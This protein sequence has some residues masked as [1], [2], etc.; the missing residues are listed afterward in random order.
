MI[1][2]YLKICFR[3]LAKHTAYCTINILGLSIGIACCLILGLYLSIELNYDKHN[4]LHERIYRVV[5]ELEY[6]GNV[7]YV[8]NTSS[9]LGPF[10]ARDFA[11]V[12]DYVRFR[13][14]RRS[15][16]SIFRSEDDSFYWE[17][18]YFADDNLFQLFTHDIIYGDPTTALVDP[19]SIAVSESFATM[20]FGG[21]NPLG[22]IISNDDSDY[23]I[24]LVFADLPQ[25]SHLN[26]EA[27]ISYNG[28]P[29]PAT[30][31]EEELWNL[32]LYTYVLLP[33]DFEVE[34][35]EEI[36]ELFF[37]RHMADRARSLGINAKRRF[38]VEPLANIHLQSTTTSDLPRGNK[39][40]VYGSAVIAAFVLIVA[41]INYMNLAT[42]LS[43]SKAYEVGMRKILGAKKLHLA[44]QVIGESLFLTLLSLPLAFLLIRITLDYTPVAN[45]L[46]VQLSMGMFFAPKVIALI[47]AATISLGFLSGFY[48]AFYL[49]AI[50]PASVFKAGTTGK[51]G[52]NI[53]K[54]LIFTQFTASVCILAST[55]MML[56]QMSY[57]N[58][59]PLGF[60]KDNKMLIRVQGADQVQNLE[61][62]MNELDQV[63]GIIGVARSANMFG[64]RIGTQALMV[65]NNDG[66]PTSRNVSRMNI[67]PGFIDVIGLELIEGRSFEEVNVDNLA[68]TAI[69]NETLANAMGWD[70]SQGKN[71]NYTVEGYEPLQVIGVLK[72]FHYRGL[73]QEI[74]PVVITVNEPDF[75]QFSSLRRRLYSEWLV[76][77]VTEE[78]VPDIIEFLQN[79]WSSFDSEHPFEF[80]FLNDSLNEIYGSE[81]REMK[82]IGVFSGICIFV[83]CMGLFGLSAF[84]TALRKKEIGVRKVL[85]ATASS[86]IFMLFKNVL[87]LILSASL[88]ASILSYWMVNIW[89]EGFYYRID[90]FSANLTVYIFSAF[91]VLTVAFVTMAL[92]SLKTVHANPV[93]ALRYE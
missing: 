33:E 6:E 69:V 53:R 20:Y 10:L 43:S 93:K 50:L 23:T 32:M 84:T 11:E 51:S 55:L 78:S 64:G 85:G 52:G 2:T 44:T 67:R 86:I 21:M 63:P 59:R 27:V 76:L 1:P 24:S 4:T 39:T 62:L 31:S 30:S 70:S 57:I 5:N 60:E 56:S 41:C 17:N 71:I 89:L 46:D 92:Q 65:D 79:R 18:I 42:A 87:F 14:L 28:F 35:F 81:D 19:S 40:Y 38:F 15:S 7:D 91:I 45:L 25:N 74:G 29:P 49:S 9:Q 82:L 83:A 90:N 16:R 77:D 54:A 36:S 34:R 26:Y 12:Q 75:A 61:G 58:S 88:L 80:S 13:P 72:D 73:Q 68:N 22:Q 66:V 48:P 8:A 37:E 47:L 3:N